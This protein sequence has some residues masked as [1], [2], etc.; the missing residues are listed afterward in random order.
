MSSAPV[1]DAATAAAP[2]PAPTSTQAVLSPWLRMQA[3]NLERHTKGLRPFTRAEFGSGA[4]AP[5]DGHILSVNQLMDRLRVDLVDGTKRMWRLAGAAIRRPEQPRLTALVDLKH[6]AHRRILAIEKIWDFYLE[7]FG[8]RQSRFAPWLVSCDRIALDCYQD[9]FVGVGKAKPIPA[10]PP[11]SYMR[12]G[13]GPATYR[14]LI[15]LS[16]LGRQ[17]NPFP[18]IQLPYH[19]LINPWTLGAVLHEVSHNLQTDLG[20]SPAVPRAIGTALS[21]AGLPPSVN[22]V[23]V[24]WNRETFADM[25]GLL[26]GGPC[27]VASLMDVIGRSP[28]VVYAFDPNGVHPTPYLRLLLSTELLRRMGFPEESSRFMRAWMTLYPRPKSG[29]FPPELLRTAA[30]AIRTVVDTICYRPYPEL[31]GKRLSEVF[32]FA[33]KDQRLVEQAARRLAAGT[34]PGI[35]PERYLIGAARIA[36]DQRLAEPEV[37]RENFYRDLA[38]R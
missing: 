35:V 23:W 24:R 4:E 6:R 2:A 28:E 26:L 34:D 10:P 37:I 18:L 32:R 15:P 7:L 16:R 19:R 33:Q 9:A 13:F 12:T 38:R 30:K 17:L 36:I 21:A 27:I 20:L 29:T 25:S 11:F 5:S 31:G 3:L 14:R 1:L 8:Q 22:A